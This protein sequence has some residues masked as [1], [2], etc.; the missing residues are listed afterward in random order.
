M[1]VVFAQQIAVDTNE[2]ES[3]A[4]DVLHGEGLAEEDEGEGNGE[5]LAKGGHSHRYERP[6]PPHEGQHD[7]HPG[8]ARDGVDERAPVLLAGVL[9]EVDDPRDE[10]AGGQ[11]PYD[12][13]D[14]PDAVAVED[15]LGVAGVVLL[16]RLLL[17]VADDGVG[18]E[19]DGDEHDP[20]EVKV[21]RDFRV[22]QGEED[23]T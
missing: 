4:V 10:V 19:R 9:R 8:I 1:A 12:Q 13:V 14:E 11:E 21:G 18:D 2:H 23:E 6:E 17:H 20:G 22:G 5:D 3:S 16:H 7:L 15:D